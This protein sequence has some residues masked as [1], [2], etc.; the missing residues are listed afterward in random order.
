V[1]C[2]QRKSSIVSELMR[3]KKVNPNICD[4]QKRTALWW[5]AKMGLVS[6]F[7]TILCTP[8]WIIDTTTKPE[9]E[10]YSQRNA[11]YLVEYAADNVKFREKNG[12]TQ[13]DEHPLPGRASFIFS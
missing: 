2:Q 9:G 4:S 7:L 6:M 12:G 11:N 10:E 5:A 3:Y 1:A 13:S 8:H